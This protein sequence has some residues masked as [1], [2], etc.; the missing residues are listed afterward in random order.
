ML[1][2]F[3]HQ[4]Q[5]IA[6]LNSSSIV[7]DTSDPGTGKT[8][9]ALEAF[10][11]ARKAGSGCALV[12][13]PKSILKNAWGNDC[14][15]FTPNLKYSIAY[16]NN[17][18]EAFQKEADL[19]ITNIDAAKWLAKQPKEFFAKFDRLIVDE[20]TFFKHHT[21][22]RSKALAKIAPYFQ[23]RELMT[24]TPNSNTILD[25][26]HQIYILDG[27]Q[28]LGRSY[29][30]FRQTACTPKQVGPSPNMVKWSDR[31]G[32]HEAVASLIGDITIRHKFEDCTDIPENFEY[33]VDFEMD[34]SHRISYEELRRHSILE[35]K[36]GDIS[37]VHA[38]SLATK[39][40]QVASGASYGSIIST[41][42]G[43]PDYLLV[44]GDRYELV[45]DLVEQR[46][47]SIV[48]FLWS[49]QRDELVKHASACGITFAV[50]DGDTSDTKREEIVA[51]YQMG[52]YRVLFAHPASAAHG[53]TLVRGT[54]T[55]WASPPYNLD[56]FIQGNRRV[57]R[58]GQTQKT[59]TIVVVAKGT[60]EEGV[61]QS[62]KDKNVNMQSLLGMLE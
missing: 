45:I 16:A 25:I 18:A 27:G 15:K 55:I 52:F 31:P 14:A 17:R 29:Y 26:W 24:G 36:Q 61:Y 2:L 19:Y 11:M 43:G 62:L 44:N 5:T 57:Y 49:H 54:A 3:Q 35:L 51:Q 38:A 58:T 60:I 37:A 1:P 7:F 23:F 46:Q 21:S 50:I 4:M 41:A 40:L 30:G 32:I 10:N 20:S 56:W 6:L 59:E 28:R 39:L 48:F 12:L 13:A 8:R 22:A 42:F 47:H 53:L 33:T 9:S 34:T